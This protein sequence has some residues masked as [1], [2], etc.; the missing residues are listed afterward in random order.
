MSSN[1]SLHEFNHDKLK[2]FQKTRLVETIY[3]NFK[4]LAAYPNLKHTRKDI[5]DAIN[6]K[7]A[8]LLLIINKDANNK[9]RIV[10]YL[11]ANVMSLNDGRK[12]LYILYI[13]TSPEFRNKG[14]ASILMN[15]I[16]ERTNDY[17]LDGVLLTC[18]SEDSFIMDFYA[19]KGFMQDLY[20]RTY[21]KYDVMFSPA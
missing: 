3:D 14:F 5:T 21:D 2:K 9:K 17:N 1:S 15:K 10:A 20:L 12:V 13:Y 18:D 7:E 4:H 19:K 16:F 6:E 11:L 8:L